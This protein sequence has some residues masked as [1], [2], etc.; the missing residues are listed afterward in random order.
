[1]PSFND[2][3][4]LDLFPRGQV[5]LEQVILAYES[6]RKNKRSSREALNFELNVEENLVELWNDLNE[7][8]YSVGP[9]VAF[10]VTKP[11]K[12]EIFAATFRDRIV[13][14]LVVNAINPI[15]EKDLIYDTY[16]CREGK[17]THL[18]IKRLD[19][20]MRSVSNNYQQEG[21]I[22]KA[23]IQSFFMS[24]DQRILHRKLVDYLRSSYTEADLEVLLVLCNLIIFNDP[25][26][27]CVI[28]S[29]RSL[30]DDLPFHKSLFNASEYKGL[31]IGNLTSQ[32]FANFYL[33][34]FDHYVKK[35]LGIRC[36]GRYVDDFV[37]VHPDKE[38][39]NLC[40]KKIT[41]F[42]KEHLG[43][44]LHPKKTQLQRI[45]SGVKFLGGV[46]ECNHINT[47]E[48]IISNFKTRIAEFN[49]L[50][51]ER[52]PSKDQRET[53]LASVNS[54]LGIL[55]HFNSYRIRVELLHLVDHR[56]WRF[57]RVGEKALVIHRIQ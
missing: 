50:I 48:R 42:L 55:R 49:T 37:L 12:R 26:K 8:A 24:I 7:G 57:F 45:Q 33:S 23:D 51:E 17:G 44:T 47:S 28:R 13:H 46:L 36:Y 32:I 9:S 31:P 16:A 39:L 19:H 56:W 54:Y 38:Y 15:I 22:L 29:P 11:V 43:L 3:L 35:G 18:G 41:V 30:W 5:T 53:F 25:T 34:E 14:H 4:E 40:R 6:C 20:F 1:M 2:Q 52:R 27:E 21:W 10:I